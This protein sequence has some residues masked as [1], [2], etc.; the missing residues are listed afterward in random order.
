MQNKSLFTPHLKQKNVFQPVN[1]Y[2]I[3]IR[4]K[5][6]IQHKLSSLSIK[7]VI[8]LMSKC[9]THP[10]GLPRGTLKDANIPLWKS[11]TY[12]ERQTTQDNSAKGKF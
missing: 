8:F 12:L 3:S 10:I 2:Y 6:Q 1:F 11:C 7:N 4:L 5:Q 9:T